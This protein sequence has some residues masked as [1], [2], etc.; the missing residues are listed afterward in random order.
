MSNI[1]KPIKSRHYGRQDPLQVLVITNLELKH[2]SFRL[3]LGYFLDYLKTKHIVDY[4]VNN[5]DYYSS[6]DVVVVQKE[7]LITQDLSRF[8]LDN[9]KPIIYETDDLFQKVPLYL[10]THLFRSHITANLNLFSSWKATFVVSTPYLSNKLKDYSND[11]TVIYNAPPF[12][13]NKNIAQTK[14]SMIIGFLGSPSRIHDF[15]VMGDALERV[16]TKYP[17]VK[18][19]FIGQVPNNFEHRFPVEYC[20]F[21]EDYQKALNRF[22]SRKPVIGLAPL[23]DNQYN[24]AKSE[25]KYIDYTYA[26]AVGIYSDIIPY[27]AIQG[28][29]LV[30]NHP[31]QWYETICRLIEDAELRTQLHEKAVED[32]K[33]RF[34]FTAEA[35]RFADILIRSACTKPLSSKDRN[36]EV[37]RL[38][39]TAKDSEQLIEFLE[40]VRLFYSVCLKDTISVQDILETIDIIDKQ[41]FCINLITDVLKELC[42]TDILDALQ[43]SWRNSFITQP[44]SN[45][46]NVELEMYQFASKERTIGAIENA[47]PVFERILQ[48]SSKPDIRAGAA[49]HL[50]EIALNC[51][52]RPKAL[53]LFIECLALNPKHRK[54]KVHLRT[55]TR[56]KT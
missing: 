7:A 25:I 27:R 42:E 56:K 41:S 53:K 51:N 39:Y 40:Y 4:H 10:G 20:R 3:R 6:A 45:V 36:I 50:G 38:A 15:A 33:A 5:L 26:G 12:A 48:K 31:E 17:L 1:D 8:M 35:E 22:R 14:E 34:S 32:I 44:Y 11:I 16:S 2:P 24:R 43:K 18:F 55:L 21:S 13:F 19:L 47:L 9:P 29:L 37:V 49:F 54:A 52:D 28:G 30:K 46:R 23:L